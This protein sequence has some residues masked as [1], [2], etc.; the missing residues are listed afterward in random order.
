MAGVL[1]EMGEAGDKG[2]VP[3]A[4]GS[5]PEVGLHPKGT[6]LPWRLLR[7]EGWAWTSFAELPWVAG[8]APQGQAGGG[9]RLQ[10]WVTRQGPGLEMPLCLASGLPT[11][12]EFLGGLQWGLQSQMKLDENNLNDV[13]FLWIRGFS[14]LTEA[15]P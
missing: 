3:A 8:E 13:D 10:P 11:S 1:G 12:R 7:G 14:L 5:C 2:Q 6:G 4:E 15:S 9:K